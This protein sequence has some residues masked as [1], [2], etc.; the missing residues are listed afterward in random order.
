MND[1]DQDPNAGTD[2][3]SSDLRGDRPIIVQ[4]AEEGDRPIIVQ[5]ATTD[6]TGSGGGSTGSGGGSTGGG[7]TTGT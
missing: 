1:N 7:G 4:D 3:E 6:T 2:E 5:G